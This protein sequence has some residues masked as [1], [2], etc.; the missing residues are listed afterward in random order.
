MKGA[1][2]VSHLKKSCK[3]GMPHV[4]LFLEEPLTFYR[5]ITICFTFCCRKA[6]GVTNKAIEYVFAVTLDGFQGDNNRG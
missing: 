2:H 4:S 5:A 1:V 3:V 6:R